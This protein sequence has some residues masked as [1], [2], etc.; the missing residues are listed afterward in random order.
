MLLQ[1]YNQIKNLNYNDYCNYLQEKYGISEFS[2]FDDRSRKENLHRHHKF[3]NVVPNLSNKDVAKSN[4]QEWQEG[5]NLVYCDRLEHALLHTMIVEETSVQ[6][7]LGQGGA[8]KLISTSTVKDEMWEIINNRFQEAVSNKQVVLEHNTV[9]YKEVE[10]NLETKNK[11]LVVLGTGLG[12]T[13][14][15]LEYIWKHQCRALV[16]GPNNLIKCGWEKYSAFVD[17]TTYQT[18]ANTYKNIDYSQYGLVVLD[19]VHHVGFDEES[20]KGAEV[21]SRGIHYILDKGIKVLGLTATPKRSDNIDVGETIFKD[22]VCE[23]MSVEDAINANIIHPVSYV[24]AYYN[25]DTILEDMKEYDFYATTSKLLGKLNV[26]INNT[27]TLKSIFIKHMPKNTKRKG[28]IFIQEIADKE[29]VINIMK[30]VFPN[31]EYRSID[32]KMSED[33][34]KEN[35]AWFENVDEG[36]LLSVN[37][38]SEG[39]HYKGV[40][41]LIMFRRTKSYL[42]FAQQFGRVITLVK[43]A[44]PNAIIFDLVNNI[45]SIEYEEKKSKK[46][47]HTVEKIIEALKLTEAYKSNQ[48]IIADETRDIVKCIK[49]IKDYNNSSWTDWEDEIIRAYYPTEGAEGC[50]KRINAEWERRENEKN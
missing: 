48:I 31:L 43:D 44:N 26:A 47:T 33:E 13:S 24:T 11:A 18:F 8:N 25:T 42:V 29:D 2:Y 9:L 40:N 20:D 19:E 22:C 12:K 49:E 15:A 27:P 5:I 37:M 4:P 38:I 39:A 1:E 34:V 6:Q 32:S 30:D 7:C 28:I 41:T 45:D 17:T 35:R 21:W 23:G 3:E 16:I 50:L 46:T 36:Y 14:T 10:Y